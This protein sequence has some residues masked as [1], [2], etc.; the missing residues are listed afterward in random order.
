MAYTGCEGGVLHAAHPEG[1]VAMLACAHRRHPLGGAPADGR[2]RLL[3]C[4]GEPLNR[5]AHRRA[6]KHLVGQGNGFV[7]DNWWQ[8]EITGLAEA[9]C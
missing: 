6:Q 9:R 2:L 3:A 7:V 4:A 8:T 5:E 1:I